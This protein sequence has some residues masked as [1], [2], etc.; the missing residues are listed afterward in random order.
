M[1]FI[2]SHVFMYLSAVAL[3][4]VESLASS[5]FASLSDFMQQQFAVPVA[6]LRSRLFPTVVIADNRPQ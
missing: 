2:R 3:G 4:A 1:Q 6:S 5:L